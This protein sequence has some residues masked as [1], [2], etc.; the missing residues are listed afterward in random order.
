MALHFFG[1][2]IFEEKIYKELE[3]K[4]ETWDKVLEAIDK[5]FNPFKKLLKRDHQRG[6]CQI[7]GEACPQNL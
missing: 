4:H 2:N 6:Y 5:A 1:K 3:K 7:N